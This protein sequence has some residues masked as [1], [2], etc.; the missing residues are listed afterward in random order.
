MTPCTAPG[1]PRLVS[2]ARAA[3]LVFVFIVMVL[4]PG[5]RAQVLS[6]AVV[7]R[8]SGERGM[9]APSLAAI[10]SEPVENHPIGLDHSAPGG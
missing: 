2:P 8:P 1:A 6:A 7:P 9:R 10:L 4:A 5:A 3:A